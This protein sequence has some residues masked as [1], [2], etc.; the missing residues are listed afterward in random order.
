MSHGKSSRML[1]YM[2]VKPNFPGMQLEDAKT[3]SILTEPMQTTNN[4]HVSKFGSLPQNVISINTA[5]FTRLIPKS[6]PL[7]NKFV[8]LPS[9]HEL[10]EPAGGPVVR[11]ENMKFV[12]SILIAVI[13]AG[14]M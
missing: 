6:Y 8:N 4:E 12:G 11:D 2:R 3:W 7:S 10:D 5:D 14:L 1:R 13:T 9:S